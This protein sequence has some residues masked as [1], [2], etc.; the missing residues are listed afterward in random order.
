[1]GLFGRKKEG[2][3]EKAEKVTT[4]DLNVA[5]DLPAGALAGLSVEVLGSGCAK[6]NEL[7]ENVRSALSEM[8]LP[9]SISHVKDFAEI[10]AYGVMSTPALVVNKKVVSCGRVLKKAEVME[11]LKGY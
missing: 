1:M 2:V 9:A 10:A 6:C 5:A 4:G 7:E 11:L 3:A 8:G